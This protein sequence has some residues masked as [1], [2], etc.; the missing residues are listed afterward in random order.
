MFRII[1]R[2][3]QCKVYQTVS[4][5]GSK[6]LSIPRLNPMNFKILDFGCFR[7]KSGKS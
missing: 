2:C 6:F 1:L 3:V 4:N 7:K 5:S